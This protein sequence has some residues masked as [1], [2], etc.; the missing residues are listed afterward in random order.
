MC[1][2]TTT[3]AFEAPA[4]A[5]LEATIACPDLG[6]W[7]HAASLFPPR[8][9]HVIC[10]ATVEWSGASTKLEAG[11][12]GI[13]RAEGWAFRNGSCSGEVLQLGPAAAWEQMRSNLEARTP[14]RPQPRW[15]VYPWRAFDTSGTEVKSL[16][17]VRPGALLLLYEGGEFLWPAVHEGFERQ[18]DVGLHRPVT[19]R[20]VT[21]DPVA[22]VIDDFLLE[23][24]IDR[25]RELAEPLL[26]RSSLQLVD[27]DVESNVRDARTSTQT[28]LRKDVD[29]LI[30]N[31]S[32]RAHAQSRLNG[33]H[34]D[35]QILRYERGQRYEAHFDYFDPRS[36]LDQPE[37]FESLKHRRNRVLTSF[38]YLVSPTL[39]GETAFPRANGAP[40]PNQFHNCKAWTKIP[41][42]RGRALFFYSLH[43]DASL[44]PASQ[45]SGCAVRGG[46]KWSA[47]FW[48]WNDYGFG[49]AATV[50]DPEIDRAIRE[51]RESERADSADCAP[52][53]HS[54][55]RSW[56]AQGEC[57]TNPD[58]ML[59][60]CPR[61]CRTC[62]SQRK[63]KFQTPRTGD[64]AVENRKS[65]NEEL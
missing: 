47:N 54:N 40:A 8:G 13:L 10:M 30:A 44:N 50:S 1:V 25:I 43:A 51:R 6:S 32:A 26:E 46:V 14:L 11:S 9:Y 62:K 63:S 53:R 19:M 35:V 34:E 49:S 20:T 29:P 16:E 56:A 7:L 17:E 3:A 42:R 27:G 39:G 57:E 65:I 41:A 55:C 59:K 64:A 61:S 31:L 5:P 28:F 2:A 60:N 37:W 12:A 22:F 48:T 36:Y 4:I 21:I 15:Q 58:Y 23:H 52:N 33:Y 24:E 38:W 45:H 18:L